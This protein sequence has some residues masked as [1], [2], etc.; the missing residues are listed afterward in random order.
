MSA[1]TLFFC[2]RDYSLSIYLTKSR[3]G[4]LNGQ[5]NHKINNPIFDRLDFSF[6][7]ESRD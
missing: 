6:T 3:D 5:Q 4:L 7:D 2:V 1:Y